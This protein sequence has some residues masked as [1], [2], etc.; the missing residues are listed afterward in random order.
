MGQE[1][2]EIGD[3]HVAGIAGRKHVA[4]ARA[5]LDGLE[6]RQAQCPGLADDADATGGVLGELHVRREGDA[7][8]LREIHQADAIRTDDA[9]ATGTGQR[10]QP[11]LQRDAF[12]QSGFTETRCVDHHPTDTQVSTLLDHGLDQFASHHDDHA[13]RHLR[14][15]G[16]R[17]VTFAAIDVVVTLVDQIDRS[18]EMD[19]VELCL[20]AKR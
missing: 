14:Q 16:Q 4:E 12:G 18:A 1:L 19:H 3:I 8:P 17:R 9:Q 10:R 2:D 11:L 20:G 6:Q 13:V 5:R 7:E 15:F